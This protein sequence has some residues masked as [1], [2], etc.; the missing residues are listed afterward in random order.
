MKIAICA[1]I[2][3]LP[4][5]QKIKIE[6]E[7]LGHEVKIPPAEVKNENGAMFPA[8][9]CYNRRKRADEKDGWIWQR[10]KEAMLLHFEKVSWADAVLVLNYDKNNIKNYI[11]PNTLIEMALALYLDKKIFLL[12]PI[13]EMNYK[14]EILGV[15]PIVINGDLRLI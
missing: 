3:F 14:E 6:L 13:P 5:M 8:L 7:Q 11:G 15:M 9:E 4:K 10:K 12:N 1:S 2:A